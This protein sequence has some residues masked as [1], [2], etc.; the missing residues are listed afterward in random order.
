MTK[1]II[2]EP[3]T[4]KTKEL[5]DI[6]AKEGAILACKNPEAM[7]VKAYAY[8]Y[9]NVELISY[10]DYLINSKQYNGNVYFDDIDDFLK[11]IGCIIKGFGGNS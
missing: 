2:R 9:K 7:R 4:G 3:S 8:G 6:C 1:K 10:E 11:S 5:I